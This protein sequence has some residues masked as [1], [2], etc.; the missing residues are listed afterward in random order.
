MYFILLTMLLDARVH[1]CENTLVKDLYIHME[2]CP[3][4]YD[5]F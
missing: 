1:K 3:S 5:H 2:K 4:A